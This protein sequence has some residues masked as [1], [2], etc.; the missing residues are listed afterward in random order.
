MRALRL[1]VAVREQLAQ[2]FTVLGLTVAFLGCSNVTVSKDIDKNTDLKDYKTFD[3]GSTHVDTQTDDQWVRGAITKELADRKI[4]PV[5]PGEKADFLVNYS[6]KLNEKLVYTD[7]DFTLDGRY[8]T[9]GYWE[10]GLNGGNV[11]PYEEGKFD[12]TFFDPARNKTF[13]KADGTVALNQTDLTAS[14]VDHVMDK[15]FSG[16]PAQT[17]PAQASVG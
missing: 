6:Q 2:Y 7:N 5:N 9:T 14:D 11:T 15:I 17:S 1:I 13:W 8:P 12:I 16:Y 3:W 10:P 4:R